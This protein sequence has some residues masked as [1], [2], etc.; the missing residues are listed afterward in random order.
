M[1]RNPSLPPELM[2][3]TGTKRKIKSSQES[4]NTLVVNGRAAAK[5]PDRVTV[6][7]DPDD[8]TKFTLTEQNGALSRLCFPNRVIH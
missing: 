5:N 6:V 7:C 2:N 3:A 4:L 1:A 8:Y